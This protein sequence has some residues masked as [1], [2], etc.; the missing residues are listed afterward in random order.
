MEPRMKSYNRE[1][2]KATYDNRE[3]PTRDPCNTKEKKRKSSYLKAFLQKL[4]L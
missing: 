1:S 4:E 2:T 3:V